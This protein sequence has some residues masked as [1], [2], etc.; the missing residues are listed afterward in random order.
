[1][2]ERHRETDMKQNFLAFFLIALTAEL[3]T[4]WLQQFRGAREVG[5]ALF[6]PDLGNMIVNRLIIWLV[7]FLLLSTLWILISRGYKKT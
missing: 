5:G 1:V 6:Y 3:G 4:S 7:L 2:I